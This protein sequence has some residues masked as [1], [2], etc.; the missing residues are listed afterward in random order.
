MQSNFGLQSISGGGMMGSNGHFFIYYITTHATHICDSHLI[1]IRGFKRN[2][3]SLLCCPDPNSVSLVAKHA[4]TTDTKL[5]RWLTLSHCVVCY[6]ATSKS[7]TMSQE[8]HVAESLQADHRLINESSRGKYGHP[9][10]ACPIPAQ[11]QTLE[12]ILM[13]PIFTPRAIMAI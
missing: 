3:K 8:H 10:E 5:S 13:Y 6:I 9:L 1:F 4:V 12:A 2:K 7:L 11:L